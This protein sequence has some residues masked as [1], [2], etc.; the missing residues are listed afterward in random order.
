MAECTA[1]PVKK[2]MF[3]RG[4]E[5]P[6]EIEQRKCQVFD[7]GRRGCKKFDRQ[8]KRMLLDNDR[9]GIQLLSILPHDMLIN[10][11]YHRKH[12]TLVACES[13]DQLPTWL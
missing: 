8:E 4:A 5:K 11:P 10:L 2:S 3:G 13:L 9:P 6:G 7:S 1:E 12:E